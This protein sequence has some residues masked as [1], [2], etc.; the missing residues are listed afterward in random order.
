[1]KADVCE[2]VLYLTEDEIKILVGGADENLA[3]IPL[4]DFLRGRIRVP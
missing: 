2:S 4:Y 1:M 3:Q